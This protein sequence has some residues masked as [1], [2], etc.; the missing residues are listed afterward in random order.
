MGKSSLSLP[1]SLAGEGAVPFAP[2]VHSQFAVNDPPTL[3]IHIAAAGRQSPPFVSFAMPKTAIAKDIGILHTSASSAASGHSA[4]ST[5][6]RAQSSDAAALRAPYTRQFAAATELILGRIREGPLRHA[7]AMAV[8][9]HASRQARQAQVEA[10]R[11]N[12][13]SDA[14]RQEGMATTTFVASRRTATNGPAPHSIIPSVESGAKRRRGFG[15][16]DGRAA[17]PRRQ[18]DSS[19]LGEITVG[20]V[21]TDTPSSVSVSAMSED[22]TTAQKPSLYNPDAVKAVEAARRRLQN[23]TSHGFDGGTHVRCERCVRALSSMFNRMVCCS[24]CNAA[25]HQ[26]CHEPEIDDSL[27]E[28]A[29]S[30]WSCAKCAAER[31]RKVGPK[32]IK[33][34]SSGGS[35][36]GNKK[37][38]ISNPDLKKTVGIGPLADDAI[39][40]SMRVSWSDRSA[41]QV[42][43][44]LFGKAV[45]NST[46]LL[47]PVV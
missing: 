46:H 17:S 15:R 43:F 5:A 7:D 34:I 19:P 32:R 21:D 18:K 27:I 10:T 28:H 3:P 8:S 47:P 40:D 35:D 44:F 23:I 33:F 24:S 31:S 22:E 6:T 42:S 30:R 9:S 39:P 16:E 12:I 2:S 45:F 41:G 11:N 1:V 36:N 37:K 4:P 13:D 20:G 25:W 14:R 26:L 38:L 29:D